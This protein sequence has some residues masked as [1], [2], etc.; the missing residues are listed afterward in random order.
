M[1]FF[2]MHSMEHVKHK[3]FF[4]STT[5]KEDNLPKSLNERSLLNGQQSR[6]AY[7]NIPLEFLENLILFL[8]LEPASRS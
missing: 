5:L 4:L 7:Y 3:H 6:L 2:P 1:E 8:E